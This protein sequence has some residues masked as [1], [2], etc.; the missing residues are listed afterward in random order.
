MHAWRGW[1]WW[2]DAD[3]FEVIVGSILVQN[4][5]WSNVERALDRLRAAD[6]LNPNAMRALDDAKLEELVRPSGQYRQKTKK[7][8]A[9][10]AVADAHGSLENLLAL[11]PATLRRTLLE[12]WGIGEETADCI[13]VYAARQPAFAIDAYTRRIFSRLGLGPGE[14]AS[15]GAWQQYFVGHI[16]E[17]RDT[18]ARYH[19]L[20]VMH[21]KHICRKQRPLCGEC[22]LAPGCGWA[23]TAWAST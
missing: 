17:D 14:N 18:W 11:D 7:L 13:V 12:T 15:Y 8:R 2:P 5:A 20:I 6:A 22:S 19:A 9:F 21:A 10:L 4:T 3:P 23:G 1:H 16:A